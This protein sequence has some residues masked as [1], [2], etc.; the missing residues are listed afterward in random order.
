MLFLGIMP[1][2][3]SVLTI[4]ITIEKRWSKVG[5]NGRATFVADGTEQAI[6]FGQPSTEKIDIAGR[7]ICQL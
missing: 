1:L 7:R 6:N 3:E 5:E 4:N 2:P